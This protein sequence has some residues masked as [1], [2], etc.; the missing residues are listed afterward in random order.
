MPRFTAKLTIFCFITKELCVTPLHAET[1]ESVTPVCG[2]MVPPFVSVFTVYTH[3]TIFPNSFTFGL[4]H[5][6]WVIED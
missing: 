1:A 5:V 3:W 2:V 6:C 4:G